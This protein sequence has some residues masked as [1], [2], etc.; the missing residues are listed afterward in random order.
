MVQ[1]LKDLITGVAQITFP[2]VCVCCGSETTPHGQLICAFC[3]EG[4]FEEANSANEPASSDTL[5]PES[6]LAQHSLWNFDKGGDLQH[7]L[8]R[9]KYHGMT[10]I[11]SDMGRKLGERIENHPLIKNTISAHDSII[12]PVPLHY[13]RFRSRGFNQSF[14][15]AQGF[16]QVWKTLEICEIDA[17]VRT[18]KTS[19]Q[20]GF[21]A[22][23]RIENVKNAFRVKDPAT[24]KGKLI[25]IID[26]V[27][28]T[29]A[30]TFE[31]AKTVKKADSGPVIILTIAQA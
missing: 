19:T 22:Q 18:K 2:D 11:G 4:R 24:V 5:L 28:T 14:K 3:L 29:G 23:K 20:T 15:I 1:F 10:A 16:L 26:D 12:L 27:F 30:T 17:V 21:S 13:L 7:L 25:I 8:H 31:L 6:V 9:L